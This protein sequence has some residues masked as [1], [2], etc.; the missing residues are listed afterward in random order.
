MHSRTRDR[1]LVPL[2]PEIERTLSRRRIAN[3]SLSLSSSSEEEFEEE[4]EQA[5]GENP[6]VS[7]NRCL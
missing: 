6:R 5:M 1:S 3:R 2:D 4:E 7:L